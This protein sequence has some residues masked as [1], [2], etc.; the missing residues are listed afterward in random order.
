[1]LCLKEISH[2][3][4]KV[5]GI[6]GNSKKGGGGGVCGHWLQGK[7]VLQSLKSKL[8]VKNCSDCVSQIID[9][10]FIESSA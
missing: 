5:R 10:L 2:V 8:I 6:S 7:V 1:M 3:Y 9:P 4:N